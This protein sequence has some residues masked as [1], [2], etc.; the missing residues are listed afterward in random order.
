MALKVLF[1]HA[2]KEARFYMVVMP[3]F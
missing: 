3:I 2:L 1:P